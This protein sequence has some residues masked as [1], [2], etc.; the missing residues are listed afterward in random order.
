MLI[1]R[2]LYEE[3]NLDFSEVIYAVA[4]KSKAAK[5]RFV[6][7]RYILSYEENDQKAKR[8]IYRYNQNQKEGIDL[9]LTLIQLK[10]RNIA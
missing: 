6:L 3:H 5:N 1:V 8:Y 9:L 2:K 4:Y 7:I 10:W